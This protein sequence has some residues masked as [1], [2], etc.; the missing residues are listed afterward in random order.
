MLHLIRGVALAAWTLAAFAIGA[1]AGIL[2]R[3]V[4]PAMFATLAVWAGLT[5]ATGSFLRRHHEAS[6]ITTRIWDLAH[7]STARGG[8]M[9]GT[10]CDEG[11]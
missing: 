1:L 9:P 5:Y 10:G 6:P 4:I 11:S 2:I 8:R 3:R 7:V